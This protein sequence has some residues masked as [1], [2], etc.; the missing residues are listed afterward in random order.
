[1]SLSRVRRLGDAQGA[2]DPL[3]GS[4]ADFARPDG[5]DLVA[6]THALVPWLEARHAAGV[7]PYG[8]AVRGGIGPQAEAHASSS[9]SGPG[10]NFA[11]QDYLSL[12]SH[13]AVHEAAVQAIRTSGVHSGGSAA[14]QGHSVASRALEQELGAHLHCEHVVLFSTGWGAAFGAVTALVRPDDHVVMDRL[15]HASLQAGAAHATP[16]VHRVAHLS[17]EAVAERLAAIRATDAAHGILVITEG[18]FSMDSDSPDL[19]ALQAVCHAQGATLLVDVAHDLGAL[20]PGGTG[21]IGRSGL[22]G[23]VDVVMGSFSKTF[24]ANGG[25]VATRHAGVRAYVEAYGGPHV[26]SNALSPVQVA[27]VRAALQIVRSAEGDARR[28]HLGDAV[29]ALR[30]TLAAAG[31]TVL[32]DP[33]AVVP[34]LIGA[35][36]TARLACREVLDAGVLVNLVEYPA[37]GVRAARLRLQV[38]ADHTSAM[39]VAAAERVIAGVEAACAQGVAAV[40]SRV[41]GARPG[42]GCVPYGRRHDGGQLDVAA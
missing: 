38:Q 31:L 28:K 12:A 37:V 6:R 30:H 18:L 5:P 24:A 8:R 9:W 29:G 25:F 19:A 40:G 36:A 16:N 39:A 17:T 7:L 27:T 3:R 14:L 22:L 23:T 42:S 13:P 26:F 11:S 20:G 32:G 15:A 10:L 34:V 1:M 4:L 33:S 41:D 35:T 21:H 2:P